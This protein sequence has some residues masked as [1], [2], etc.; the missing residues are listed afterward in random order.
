DLATAAAA[1]F[2]YGAA[3]DVTARDLQNR[4]RTFTRA[5]CFDTFC[6]LGPAIRLGLPGADVTVVTRVNGEER[7][8]GRVADMAWGP[9]DLVARLL[10]LQQ[11]PGED[12]QRRGE[13]QVDGAAE[14]VAEQQQREPPRQQEDG[15]GEACHA[16]SIPAMRRAALA[17]ARGDAAMA[18]AFR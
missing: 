10:P 18:A 16:G 14:R 13:Q 9:A 11:P 1:V 8:R 4:D 17:Y 6:P 12:H 3:C 2:G 15:D 5:K 7:Q